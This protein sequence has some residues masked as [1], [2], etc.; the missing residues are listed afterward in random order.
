MSNTTRAPSTRKTV[1]GMG[2]IFQRGQTFWIAYYRHGKEHRESTHSVNEN[3]ATKLLKKRY[4]EIAS[5]RFVGPQEE[6]VMFED[7]VKGIERDY[8]LRGLRSTR[9]AKGRMMHLKKA[10]AG[11]RALDITPDRVR[12]YQAHRRKEKA[13]PATVNRETSHLARAFRIA[14]KSCLLTVVPP[15]PNRLEES[16]PRQGFFEHAEYL[17][18]REHLTPAVYQD[19]LDFAY[20]SGWRRGEVIGLTWRE[21]DMAGSVI[22]LDPDRSKTRT[23]R[24]LPMSQPLKEVLQRRVA[25]RRLDCL[26][27]FHR[28]RR[29]GH[30]RLVEG[31]EGSVQARGTAGQ[32]AARL[33][34]HRSAQLD[35]QRHAGTRGDAA[36]RSQDALGFR[37]LQH[38]ER[39][40]SQSRRRAT[41]RVREEATEGNDR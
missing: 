18:V 5:R 38:R 28:R 35:P 29:R 16:A 32:E 12:D 33:P 3:D 23:G 37:S 17:A 40:R 20:Y 4:G 13:S 14:V 11:M 30:E 15:F 39:E 36:H 2:R 6:R 8:E 7:L 1:P 21:I 10:F 41:R 22:R 27:V 26:M 31:V 34:A 9:A 25:A 19:I 24:L